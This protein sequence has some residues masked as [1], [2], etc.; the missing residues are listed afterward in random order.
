MSTAVNSRAATFRAP[1]DITLRE[2]KKAAFRQPRAGYRRR[3]VLVK[4]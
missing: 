1:L 3:H 2:T 4:P